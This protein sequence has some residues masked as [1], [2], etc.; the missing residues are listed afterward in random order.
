MY[1][2]I[3]D[4]KFQ[5][6]V[7]TVTLEEATDVLYQ[8]DDIWDMYNN[9]N[10][11]PYYWEAKPTSVI[12]SMSDD[13]YLKLGVLITDIMSKV[14]TKK[15]KYDVSFLNISK[16]KW[17]SLN[18]DVLQSIG[19]KYSKDSIKLFELK[20]GKTKPSGYAMIELRERAVHRVF[21]IL[22][23]K[24]GYGSDGEVKFKSRKKE[25]QEG[26]IKLGKFHNISV[27]EVMNMDGRLPFSDVAK[28]KCT[29]EE[30]VKVTLN[31]F[32][33]WWNGI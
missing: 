9:G 18:K 12:V 26:V 5:L 8:L 2:I 20:P 1:Q 28:G 30:G 11:I 14:K 6:E 32:I 19:L 25:Q 22:G 21:D 17:T 13:T 10:K 4:D 23:Q 24:F 27:N 33:K 31:E 3:Q 7:K 15:D 29:T 16:Y